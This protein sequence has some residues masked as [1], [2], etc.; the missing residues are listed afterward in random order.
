MT[1]KNHVRVVMCKHF[2]KLFGRGIFVQR[3]KR[4]IVRFPR[5]MG[6]NHLQAEIFAPERKR[7]G[8]RFF[9]QLFSQT[10]ENKI[11]MRR[12]NMRFVRLHP[13]VSHEIVVMVSPDALNVGM[14][15]KIFDALARIRPHGN[16][17][18]QMIY[19]VAFFP[20]KQ[21]HDC[22]QRRQIAVRIGKNTYFFAVQNCLP[23]IFSE[24]AANRLLFCGCK[25]QLQIV[26][27]YPAR[28]S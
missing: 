23:L 20:V 16:H 22:F 3:L 28:L 15:E 14:G 17:I 24:H 4:R 11:F 13:V 9:A 26:F 2:V 19:L 8:F 21:L 10:V 27:L 25:F 5:V 7:Y 1:E 12:R 6:E 18:A